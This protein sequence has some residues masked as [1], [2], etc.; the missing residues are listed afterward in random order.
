MSAQGQF[1]GLLQNYIQMISLLL[2]IIFF[3]NAPVPKTRK[4]AHDVLFQ[5]LKFFLLL[6]ALM[7]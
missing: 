1:S 5:F 3:I 2:F 6:V 4:L 7:R